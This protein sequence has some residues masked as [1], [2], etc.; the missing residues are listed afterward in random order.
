MMDP[1]LRPKRAKNYSSPSKLQP[2]QHG[3][4]HSSCAP[5]RECFGVRSQLIH[6]RIKTAVNDE[7]T[8]R[9]LPHP[10]PVPD[11]VRLYCELVQCNPAWLGQAQAGSAQP[12]PTQTGPDQGLKPIKPHKH[13]DFPADPTPPK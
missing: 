10:G 13:A 9:Y 12:R 8:F 4:Q 7:L 3:Y 2:L 1:E 5:L 11:Q 6:S